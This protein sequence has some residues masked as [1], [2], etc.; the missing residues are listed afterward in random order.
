[1][2]IDKEKLM[3]LSGKSDAELWRV[4][5]EIAGKHGYALPK[6]TP[7]KSEMDKIRAIMGNAD[8]I[9][10]REAMRIL[11]EYKRRG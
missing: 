2:K 1:M 6:N 5:S 7:E 4:I 10:M 8:K 3:E 9:N 11:Q